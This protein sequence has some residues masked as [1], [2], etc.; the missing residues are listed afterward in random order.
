MQELS[1]QRRLWSQHKKQSRAQ[2]QKESERQVQLKCKRSAEKSSLRRERK[3]QNQA[4]KRRFAQEACRGLPR[5][6]V[7]TNI[8]DKHGVDNTVRRVR[9]S[10]CMVSH[11]YVVVMYS[12]RIIQYALQ[13]VQESAVV[14]G[15]ASRPGYLKMMCTRSGLKKFEVHESHVDRDF[16]E[17]SKFTG[18]Y[19]RCVWLRDKV[20]VNVECNVKH[21]T[22]I[23]TCTSQCV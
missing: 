2:Q 4:K 21:D 6:L 9:T 8:P 12:T 18:K 14:L 10:W 3:L 7:P 13:Y 20:K 5:V 19:A 17:R 11:L 22:Y 16:D 1:T 23:M 15:P